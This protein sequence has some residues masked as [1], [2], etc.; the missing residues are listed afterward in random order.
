MK[1]KGYLVALFTMLV[2]AAGAVTSFFVFNLPGQKETVGQKAKTTSQGDTAK[3]ATA[4]PV[5]ATRDTSTPARSKVQ[6]MPPVLPISKD[7]LVKTV[8]TDFSD[9]PSDN[10]WLVP[11]CVFGVLA[12]FFFSRYKALPHISAEALRKDMDPPELTM[13]L[14]S[15]ADE[16][17]S[18]GNPRKIKRFSNKIRFQY[19]YITGKGF[20]DQEQLK[21]LVCLLVQLEKAGV[22]PV[23][24]DIRE[25][26]GPD[27]R[28][29]RLV[30]A[31]N[32][33]LFFA[34]A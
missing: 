12:I 16:I 27:E 17:Q 4:K 2:T 11:V 32:K 14:S 10:G 15:C 29:V 25:V 18:L 34:S 21:K 23:E 31:L 19:Y 7:S 24:M 28:F 1:T 8:K 6:V 3:I 9:R 26:I 22:V 20:T 13:L 33:D 5:S 30:Y